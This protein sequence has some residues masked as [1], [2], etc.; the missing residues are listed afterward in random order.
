MSLA[1]WAGWLKGQEKLT[2]SLMA[3]TPPKFHQVLESSCWTE[4]NFRGSLKHTGVTHLWRPLCRTGLW[5]AGLSQAWTGRG[6]KEI[7]KAELQEGVCFISVSA[8]Q[9]LITVSIDAWL[10][11][12]NTL[13]QT[14]LCNTT[15][16]ICVSQSTIKI[17][18]ARYSS[19]PNTNP[20]AFQPTADPGEPFAPTT[21]CDF[22]LLQGKIYGL[23]VVYPLSAGLEWTVKTQ[24][25]HQLFHWKPLVSV[26]HVLNISWAV[27]LEFK[28]H[29]HIA[30]TWTVWFGP[31]SFPTFERS[32]SMQ[33][34]RAKME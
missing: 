5:S 28:G 6:C 9:E 19:L 13:L 34:C 7:R 17:T 33:V 2:Q 29:I 4:N 20:P 27:K 15:H 30:V 24:C 21:L 1:A 31:T 12:F 10:S 8:R 22:L 14:C 26:Q 11:T 3:Y 25:L 16:C 18:A 32:I 23:W